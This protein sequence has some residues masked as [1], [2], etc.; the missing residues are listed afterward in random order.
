VKSS[1]KKEKEMNRKGLSKNNRL[2]ERELLKSVSVPVQDYWTP[3]KMM[4]EIQSNDRH[5]VFEQFHYSEK[6]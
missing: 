4:M 3:R 2:I 5:V 1:L 6:C